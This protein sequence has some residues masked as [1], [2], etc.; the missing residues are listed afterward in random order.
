[1][2]NGQGLPFL[3]L[4]AAA[5]GLVATLVLIYVIW[6]LQPAQQQQTFP[7]PTKRRSWLREYWPLAAARLPAY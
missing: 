2:N 3:G 6:R 5:I 1:L 7:E 4:S